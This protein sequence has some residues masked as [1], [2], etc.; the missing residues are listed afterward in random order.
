[1][2]VVYNALCDLAAQTEAAHAA[3]KTRI[4]TRYHRLHRRFGGKQNKAAGTQAAFATAHTLI[5]IVWSVL[6]T[7][8]DYTRR[9]DPEARKKSLI[10]QLEA[11]TGNKIAL[12]NGDTG[13]IIDVGAGQTKAA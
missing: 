3:A 13:E 7:G 1:M 8:Q 9:I 5:K 6:A 11:L 2:L 10:A 12:I 4:G